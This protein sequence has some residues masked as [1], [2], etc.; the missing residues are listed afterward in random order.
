MS[1]LFIFLYVNQLAYDNLRLCFIHSRIN[2]I[3]DTVQPATVDEH[4][5]LILEDRSVIDSEFVKVTPDDLPEWFDERL[6]KL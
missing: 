4:F 1:D 6:F 5:K 3:V 2:L